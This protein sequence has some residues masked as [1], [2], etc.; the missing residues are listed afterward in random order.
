[1]KIALA[2]L[3]YFIGDFEGN[4]RKIAGRIEEAR[5]LGADLVVFS[6]LAVCGYPPRDFL[7]FADFIRRCEAVIGQLKPLSQGIGVLVGCPSVNP[8]AEGKD[9]YNSAYLLADGQ[10]QDVVH[11]ALLPTYDV[12]D[13][14]RYFEPNREFHTVEFRGQRLA[15]TICEDLWNVGNENPL[16]PSCPMDELI[17]QAPDVIINLS[18]SPFHARQAQERMEVLR[19]NCLRYQLP[20]FYANCT[21]AQTELLF[22]GGS[23]VLNARGEV[24]AELPYFEECLRVFDLQEL[25]RWKGGAAE[26]QTRV[27]HRDRIALIRRALV[28]GIRDYF[29]KL[30]FQRAVLG[31]SG[32][33]DSALT[34]ALAAEALGP[35]QVLAVLMPSPYS[36]QHSVDDSLELCANY[37]VPHISIPIQTAMEAFMEQ[38]GPHFA[39]RPFDLTEENLQAR[40]RAVYLMAL[41][42]KLGYILLNT[43]NKSEAAVGY[44]TLY[45][46]MCG[47]LSVIGDVYKTDVYALCRH[48]NASGPQIPEHILTKAPSAE[49]RPNQKDSDSLPDYADL[50]AVLYHYIEERLGP[51]EIIALGYDE[52]LVRRTLRLVNTS[53]YKRHQTPPILRVSSKAFGVGRRMPIVGK[54]LS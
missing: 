21:G 6:E 28:T 40:I 27:Q 34:L 48:I 43:S 33:V 49:L 15:L 25:L 46:D 8:R 18:A 47:G 14:Y 36:S 32:G 30:G 17:A 45:G 50:D 52:V 5:A 29:G 4:F 42:N 11:K 35:E 7:E 12:F 10:V 1:M 3:N 53:E 31:L 39:G 26:E 24:F 38:L 16:Y 20:L 22:D 54:Y 9:L 2:Q 41:S 19:Q 37:G 51:R 44:G 13:E 23:A